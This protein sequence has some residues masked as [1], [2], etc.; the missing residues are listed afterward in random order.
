MT[1]EEY[2]LFKMELPVIRMELLFNYW[3]ENREEWYFD[4]TF[5][6]FTQKFAE[7]NQFP[8]V[9]MSLGSIIERVTRYYDGKFNIVNILNQ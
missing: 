1:K 8:I 2:I 4:L 5:E 9:K 3:V 7:W 6:E